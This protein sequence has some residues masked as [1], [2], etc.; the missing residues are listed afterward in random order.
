MKMK[1]VVGLLLVA[2]IAQ[3][4]IIETGVVGG[5]TPRTVGWTING[6][7]SWASATDADLVFSIT[8]VLGNPLD[9]MNGKARDFAVDSSGRGGSYTNNNAGR[10]DLDETITIAISYV[11]PNSS[12]VS[13]QLN[14]IQCRRLEGGGEIM[15]VTDGTNNYAIDGDTQNGVAIDYSTTGLGALTAG[16]T[17]SWFMTL[18]ADPGDI[19]N[20]GTARFRI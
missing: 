20:S 10:L 1:V 3:A 17:G 16:N 19:R 5:A 13:L 8:P 11:D 18:S 7:T 9:V 14:S 12:L 15:N 2:G 6:T 4:G